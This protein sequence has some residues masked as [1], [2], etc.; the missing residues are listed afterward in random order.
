MTMWHAM[1]GARRVNRSRAL[2]FSFLAPGL[3]VPVEIEFAAG[4]GGLQAALVSGREG[5]RCLR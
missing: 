3:S 2:P 5:F 4:G 1:G